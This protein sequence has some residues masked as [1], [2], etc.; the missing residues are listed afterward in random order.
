MAEGGLAHAARD[1][2]MPG[3]A[4]SL[5]QLLETAGCGATLDV[6]ALL[7]RFA[8]AA[9]GERGGHTMVARIQ[10]PNVAFFEHLGWSADGPPGPYHGVD[11][12]PMDIDLRSF[13]GRGR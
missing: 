12:R 11:H 4:G 1:V 10:L 8:V 6:G 5:L 7:V 9:A 2:S 3:V 13:N